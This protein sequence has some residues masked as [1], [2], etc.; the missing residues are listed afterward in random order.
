MGGKV[1]SPRTRSIRT[2]SPARLAADVSGVP[3]VLV[4][5]TDADS[6]K[7]LTSDIDERIAVHPDRVTAPPGL[8]TGSRAAFDTRS[9]A[10][11]RTP[12]TRT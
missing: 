10:V 11:S 3:T 5:R 4:A 12:R 2:W 6:A 1:L 7:L 9:R 8:S